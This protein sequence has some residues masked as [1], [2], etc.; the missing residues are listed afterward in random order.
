MLMRILKNLFEMKPEIRRNVIRRLLQIPAAWV[1][2]ALLL[3]FSAGSMKWSSAWLFLVLLVSVDLIGLQFI[4]LEVLAERGSKKENVEDWDIVLG[5]RIVL[6]M[7]SIFL[8]AGL[9]YRWSWSPAM[10]TG[11]QL[12]SIAFFVFG[13]ALEIWAMRVNHFFSDVVRIQLDREHKVCSSGPYQ[14]VRHPGYLGMIIYYLAAPILL[15]SLWA[16]IPA[17]TTMALFVIRTRLED[18][19]LNQKL[20][21]YREYADRVR[22]RLLPGVW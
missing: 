2:I 13:S 20:P 16:M 12:A 21:G 6:C 8:V 11:W 17:L 3:F 18:N 1:F 7:L 4:P 15:G 9:D 14:Y 19:T 10:D 22:F 5:K